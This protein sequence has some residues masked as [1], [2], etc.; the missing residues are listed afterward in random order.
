MGFEALAQDLDEVILNGTTPSQEA[1][2]IN[3]SVESKV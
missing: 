3:V 1:S 2:E